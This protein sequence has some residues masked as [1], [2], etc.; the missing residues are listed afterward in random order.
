MIA[1]PADGAGVT[2]LR[3]RLGRL[4]PGRLLPGRERLGRLLPAGLL[5]RVRLGAVVLGCLGIVGQLGQ[6]G[7]VTKSAAYHRCSAAAIVLLVGM[8]LVTYFRGR[9][10]W[11][12]PILLPILVVIGGSGLVDPLAGISL[13]LGVSAALALYGSLRLWVVRTLGAMIAVPLAVV[14]SPVSM[15]RPV[16]WN[17]GPVIGL[18]PQLLLV[19]AL[20][21]G[22]YAALARQQQAIAREAVLARSGRDMLGITEIAAVRDRAMRAAG[23]LVD[24]TP[25]TALLV[26]RRAPDGLRIANLAGVPEQLRGTAVPD[27]VVGDPDGLCTLVPW[28]RHWRAETLADDLHIVVGGAGHVPDDVFDAFRNLAHQVVLAEAGCRTHAEM[29]HRANHDQLTQL[30]TRAKFAHRLA[31]AVDA[32]PPGSVALLNIDLDDF[33]QVND[34]YGHAAGDELLIRVAERIA[35]AGGPGS[36]AGRFGGDEFAL[37][38]TGLSRP[39]EAEEIAELLCV[40]LIAPVTLAGTTV[41]VGASIG[42]AVTVPGVTAGDLTRRADIAMYSAKAQGK[43]RV[44]AFHPDQHGDA[45]G[46]RIR[47]K[48]LGAAVDRDEIRI[49]Y[50]PRFEPR[51]GAMLAIETHACWEHPVFG[52]LEGGDLLALAERTGNLEILGRHLL[53]RTCEQIADLPGGRELRFTVDVSGQQLRD[54]AY[55]DTVLDTLAGAGLDPSRLEIEVTG[56]DP[57]DATE[58][59]ASVSGRQ[60][61]RLAER[62]VR[63][64]LDAEQTRWATLALLGAYR[65]HRLTVDAAD[66]AAIELARSVGRVLGTEIVVCGVADA[67]RTIGLADAVQ[68]DALAPRMSHDEL[69]AWLSRVPAAV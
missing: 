58:G 68:G 45:V 25:D 59:A 37:L 53:R 28:A 1:D 41:A 35:D 32:G 61:G 60:L 14:V 47:E 2:T 51:T 16:S 31:A 6:L 63:L 12:D 24:V 62:G 57:L 3:G 38:L 21:R 40:R 19:S 52:L 11:W 18:V 20:M 36:L 49:R 43:N 39:A 15:D 64:A 56:A 44:E 65:I 54:P 69:A 23:Q 9:A 34:S 26:L 10:H 67:T 7:N 8:L 5:A 50:R 29:D 27:Q 30:P 4:L 17:T 48:H 46:H 55:A 42:V 66:A 33:K 13:A 22:I